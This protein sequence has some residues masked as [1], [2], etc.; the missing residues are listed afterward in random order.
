M[1][2]KKKIILTFD[3]ELFLGEDSGS[4][5]KSLI[6]PTYKVLEILSKYGIKTTFFVDVMYYQKLLDFNLNN[7]AELVRKQLI[8]ILKSGSRIELHLHPHWIDAQWDKIGRR[9]R[10]NNYRFYKLQNL[11][12]DKIQNI[13]ASG[14]QVLHNIAREFDRNYKVMA[15]RAG[16]FCIYPFD[17]L[18]KPFKENEIKIDSSVA[19]GFYMRG[20]GHGEVDF[21]DFPN[22]EFYFFSTD[23]KRKDQNGPFLEV[24][25]STYKSIFINR[26]L[27]RVKTKVYSLIYGKKKLQFFGDGIGAPINSNIF[28]IFR[29]PYRLFSL[30]HHF[31]LELYNLC[32]NYKKDIINFISHPKTLSPLSLEG[33]SLLIKSQEFDFINLTDVLNYAKMGKGKT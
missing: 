14:I 9:W 32:K 8:E 10:L 13:F 19:Y 22:D 29:A 24:P 27:R 25:I 18:M 6:I 4:L 11:D 16:G 20:E 31:P 28:D 12:E 5:E 23:P 26:I 3:Y 15:F 2:G 21:S 7:D 17:K 33:L 1:A 30:E